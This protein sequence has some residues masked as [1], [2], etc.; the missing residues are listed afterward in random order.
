MLTELMD[1]SFDSPSELCLFVHMIADAL[2]KGRESEE[3]E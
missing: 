1:I 2:L 3:E